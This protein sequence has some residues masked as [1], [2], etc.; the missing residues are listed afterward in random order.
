MSP[1]AGIA[2]ALTRRFGRGFSVAPPSRRRPRSIGL[3]NRRLGIDL[4]QTH[5]RKGLSVWLIPGCVLGGVIAA[6]AIAHVRVELI[7]QGY[8]RVSDVKRHQQLE[9][10]QRNLAAQVRELR[11]PARLAAL[12]KE[13]G[14]ARPERVVSL[15]PPG[16]ETR[17]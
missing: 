12:A 11:D 5:M 2:T 14:L 1:L 9:E 17:P 10:E 15:A 3:A 8:Q 4:V 16:R 6:L 13:M 7:Q